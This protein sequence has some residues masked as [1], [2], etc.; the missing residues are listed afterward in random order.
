MALI[1]HYTGPWIRYVSTYDL[2]PRDLP[3]FKSTE[4]VVGYRVWKLNRETFELTS[5]FKNTTWPF[6]EKMTRGKDDLSMGIHAVKNERKIYDTNYIGPTVYDPAG[7]FASEGLWSDYKADV[8]GEVFMWGEVK[9]CPDGYL[10]EFAYPK[11]LWMPEST[12]P[13]TIM[14]LEQNYGVP[15][16]L[17]SELGPWKQNKW[18]YVFTTP[19]WITAPQM[20]V[21]ATLSKVDEEKA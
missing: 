6:R 20:I 8:A 1:R 4:P 9:D 19:T 14:Q 17:R 12:D 15:V 3:K 18:D 11:S 16:T 13:V 5:C 10:A 7:L 2:V 21:H